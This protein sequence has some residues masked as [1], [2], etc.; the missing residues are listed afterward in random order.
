MAMQGLP[1]ECQSLS[2]QVS[3]ILKLIH[4]DAPI[5]QDGVQRALQKVISPH[6]E[7]VFAGAFSAGKSMLINAL[8][9]RELLY[10]AEGHATGTECYVHY[11]KP[12][13]EQVVL[14]FLSVTEVQEQARVL[15]EKLNLSSIDELSPKTCEDLRQQCQQILKQEGGK[16]KSDRAKAAYSLSLLMEGFLAN[17]ERIHA[18]N[19]TRF[20]MKE[21]NLNNLEEAARFARRS[22]NS[23]VLRKIEYYC[24]HP[25]L[26]DG[27]ILVDT[28]GI[29]APVQKDADLTFSKIQSPDVSAVVC[30]LKT[31]SAGDPTAE[32]T[33]LMEKTRDNI[34]VRDRVFYIFNRI[35]ETWYN[36]QLR[37][38][39]EGF[40]QS[41]FRDEKR[42][43]KT[44]GLLG[45]YGG[46]IKET[47]ELDRFGLDTLFASSV[48]G[49]DAEEKE[50]IPQFVYSF[51]SYCLMSQKLRGLFKIDFSNDDS[52]NQNYVR[53]L[54]EHGRPLIEQLIK[55]SGI[56]GFRDGITRYLKEEKRPQLMRELLE[57]LR[58]VCISLG[59]YYSE[60]KAYLESQP[61]EIETIKAQELRL[62]NQD[63]NK[64]GEELKKFFAQEINE[65]IGQKNEEF[66]QDYLNLGYHMVGCMDRLLEDFSVDEMYRMAV[67][68][69]PRNSTAPFLSVLVESFYYVS[70]GL[71]DVLVEETRLIVRKFFDSLAIKLKHQD[72]YIRLCR[73]IGTDAGIEQS[74]LQLKSQVI[75]L[76]E[77][78]ARVECDTYVRESIHF[79]DDTIFSI[80]QF[81]K[82]LEK[83]SKSYDLPGALE[84][85]PSIQKL[86][87]VD[88]EPK[89]S[90]T[91]RRR[92][93]QTINQ[94]LKTNILDWAEE[95]SYLVMQQYD[96]ARVFRSQSLDQESA[97]KLSENEQRRS[98]LEASI[99]DYNQA[100]KNI[101][102]CLQA[103][104]IYEL[105]PSYDNLILPI[106]P[107]NR[108][109]QEDNPT[110]QTIL[111]AEV[112]PL[113]PTVE[114]A[115]D[116]LD[117]S[118]LNET[119]TGSSN[120]E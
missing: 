67:S 88:F 80:Y 95:Q 3:G 43:Y 109:Q 81:R 37:Q 111:E 53:I 102:Q 29:D 27:N 15:I 108:P 47:T 103:M 48:K 10:S 68:L 91:I 7:I 13:A 51:N 99:K 98:K 112:I 28:P 119:V 85:E 1:Q 90:N 92:Y 93:P 96:N 84:A 69:R 107:L 22:H 20:P 56:Q 4:T 44:S 41:D 105:L 89:V 86:L 72:F 117:P 2:T 78:A 30:V 75:R 71:E 62:L 45:F 17:Q 33:K 9:E 54:S 42:I 114:D 94:S 63:L 82:G 118:L 25:L 79:Y 120:D 70:N 26:E 61:T 83:T 35:D 52:P 73:L 36:T 16:D 46:L 58:P 8:L 64:I 11:A 74:L 32:E 113:D 39:L 59:Q 40:I 60:E 97:L 106:S 100:V 6:F 50:E 19:N 18:T 14:T 101:N 49:V 21:F 34:G 76:L 77:N 23:S 87:K 5:D 55:D 115:L 66:N 104:K 110:D 24:H 31:A 12:D 65:I 116:L 38:R 57:K